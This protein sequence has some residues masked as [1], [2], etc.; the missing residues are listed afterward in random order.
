MRFLS[1]SLTVEVVSEHSRIWQANQKISQVEIPIPILGKNFL[2]DLVILAVSEIYP[3]TFC[4]NL[5]LNFNI[6][7]YFSQFSIW[8][9]LQMVYLYI[10]IIKVIDVRRVGPWRE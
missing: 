3:K 7:P 5:Y 4:D 9:L 6:F 2:K 1:Y 10:I 8:I